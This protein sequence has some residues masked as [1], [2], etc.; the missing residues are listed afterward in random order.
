MLHIFD[1]KYLHSLSVSLQL[2]W[3]FSKKQLQKR[4]LKIFYY[5]KGENCIMNPVYSF[6]SLTLTNCQ[7][8]P[9]GFTY[10]INYLTFLCSNCVK[11]LALYCFF[12][13]S[14]L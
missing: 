5:T 13:I 2:K 1:P 9:D 7:Y 8:V 3:G 4:P 10:S 14:F 11:G 12:C 6:S